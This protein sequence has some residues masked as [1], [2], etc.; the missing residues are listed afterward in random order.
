M[1]ITGDYL[2]RMSW[3]GY[4]GASFA[5]STAA[6]NQFHGAQGTAAMV[7]TSFRYYLP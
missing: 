2:D 1:Q 7:H 4:T 5:T 6:A 3:Q